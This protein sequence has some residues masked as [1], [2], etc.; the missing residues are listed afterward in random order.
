VIEHGSIVESGDI[1]DLHD[2]GILEQRLA[3]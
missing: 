1:G 2:R 3:L